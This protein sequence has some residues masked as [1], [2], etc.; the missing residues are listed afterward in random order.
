MLPGGVGCLNGCVT[1]KSE[2]VVRQEE[3]E[4]Q[5]QKK[6]IELEVCLKSVEAKFKAIMSLELILEYY[7]LLISIIWRPLDLKKVQDFF[8]F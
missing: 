5:Q 6:V 2:V 7:N 1:A 8:L 3:E 4:Q